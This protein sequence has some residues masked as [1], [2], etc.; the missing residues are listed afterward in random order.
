MSVF[1][2]RD[3]RSAPLASPV[4]AEINATSDN[5]LTIQKVGERLNLSRTTI[6]RLM[7]KHGLRFVCIGGARRISEQDLEMWI[8]R[9]SVSLN[10]DKDGNAED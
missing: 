8:E 2:G 9:H 5:F 4:R 10:T 3:A 6:L 7:N 1:E